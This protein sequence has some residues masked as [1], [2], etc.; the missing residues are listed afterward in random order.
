MWLAVSLPAWWMLFR[1]MR[2][3]RAVVFDGVLKV[4]VSWKVRSFPLAK[5]ESVGTQQH[6]VGMVGYL[7]D[8]LLVRVE[9]TDVVL[10][11]INVPI[12]SGQLI[13]LC[14]AIDRELA[15]ARRASR[16]RSSGQQD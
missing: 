9:G 11:D 16:G 15:A 13:D 4:W 14:D 6:R 10:L 7:R 5:V 3:G 1:A 12:G 2:L 8:V